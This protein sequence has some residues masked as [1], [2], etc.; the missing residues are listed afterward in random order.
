MRPFI[1]DSCDKHLLTIN[2][3]SE[4]ELYAKLKPEQTNLN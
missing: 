4:S 1:K 2:D 3:G